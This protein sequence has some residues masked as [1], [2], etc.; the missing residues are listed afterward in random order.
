MK[1]RKV[2]CN[3]K[4]WLRCNPTGV[5]PLYRKKKKQ[6]GRKNIMFSFCRK[7]LVSFEQVFIFIY[8]YTASI[9]AIINY[10][11]KTCFVFEYNI[12]YNETSLNG[13]YGHLQMGASVFAPN[14]LFRFIPNEIKTDFV[15]A[16]S[17]RLTFSV[18][19][20]KIYR[21]L[22]YFHKQLWFVFQLS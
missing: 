19:V 8:V 9:N 15:S 18:F 14:L 5:L 10:T 12:L 6:K 2:F 4:L 3:L 20:Q 7:K 21:I 13:H 11:L 16:Q 1:R 22:F 17:K